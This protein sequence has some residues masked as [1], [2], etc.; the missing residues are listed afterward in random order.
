MT[1]SHTVDVHNESDKPKEYCGVFG[2]Y[3]PT[4][5]VAKLAYFGLFALQHRGQESAGIA[6]F[7]RE[8]IHCHKDMGLV[9]HVFSEEKLQELPGIWAVGHNRYSTTGSSHSCNAQ[10][11]IEDTR[12]G[13]FCLAHNGNLVNTLELRDKIRALDE[14]VSFAS[15]IDSEMIAKAIAI[16]VNQGKSWHDASIEAFRL[17]S[18]AFSLV[19]GT[20]DGLIGARDHYGVRPLV[21]GTMKEEDGTERYVLA[22]RM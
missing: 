2:V 1:V 9:S 12:L 19:I 17:C 16:Y 15:S 21:I 8:K 10:P 6:T 3:A 4:E 11:I 20:P 22:S 14:N 7:D 13:Q 18:G 5:E